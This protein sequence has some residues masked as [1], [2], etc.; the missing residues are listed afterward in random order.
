MNDIIPT[1]ALIGASVAALA[2]IGWFSIPRAERTSATE[3][4]P[5]DWAGIAA[6]G[7]RVLATWGPRLDYDFTSRTAAT[8]PPA[9]DVPRA[10][11]T[12]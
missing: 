1:L 8:T 10:R 2:A 9:A 4:S 6:H 3:I 12:R 11:S 5:R 7:A